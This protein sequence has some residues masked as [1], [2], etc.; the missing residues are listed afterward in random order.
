MRRTWMGIGLAG[1][2]CASAAP[3]AWDHTLSMGLNLTDGNSDSIVFNTSLSA[4]RTNLQH[5][6]RL[7]AEGNYG[8]STVDGNDQRTAENLKGAIEYKYLFTR[9]YLYSNNSI[10]RDVVADLDYRMIIGAGGGYRV[11]NT[12]PATLGLELGLAFIREERTDDSSDDSMA[13]R[14]AA[15]HDQKI[16]DTAK[17]WAM[18][19]YLPKTDAVDIYLVNSEAGIEAS[20]N[21]KA[22]FNLRTVVQHRYDSEVPEGRERSD[23]A[24]ISAF[25]CKL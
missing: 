7:Q 23:L 8:E 5:E 17:A 24:L 16:S 19:E 18:V 22:S 25:V 20:L 1:C 2:I 14:A 21:R 12:A 15:R 9:S 10:F 13:F 4:V 11:I 3:A 6:L